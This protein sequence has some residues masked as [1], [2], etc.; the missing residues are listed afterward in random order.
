MEFTRLEVLVDIWKSNQKNPHKLFCSQQESYKVQF[1]IGTDAR[2]T[3]SKFPWLD[4]PEE[5]KYRIY[6]NK[7]QGA[8]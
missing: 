5:N 6:P 8:Y 1:S 3:A 7:R 2:D 4:K